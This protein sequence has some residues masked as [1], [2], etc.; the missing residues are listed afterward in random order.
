MPFHYLRSR[1]HWACSLPICIQQIMSTADS[2]F[3]NGEGEMPALPA[4]PN[5]KD[6]E[7][8]EEALPAVA[9]NHKDKETKEEEDNDDDNCAPVPVNVV[10]DETNAND[11]ILPWVIEG[12]DEL[13]EEKLCHMNAFYVILKEW[14]IQKNY[15]CVLFTKAKHQKILNYCLD[16][17]D[18]ADC[19]EQYLQGNKQAYK[20]QDKYDAVTVGDSSIL[21][22]RPEGG[23]VANA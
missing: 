11:E 17:I 6:K 2:K 15:T 1:I 21:V 19:R 4:V 14:Y 18:G 8:E 20:L 3:F 5:H 10:L 12:A 13:D 16:L 7:S 9:P 23:A 22:R